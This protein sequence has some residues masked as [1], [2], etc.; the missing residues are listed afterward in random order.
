MKKLP[1]TLLLLVIFWSSLVV[2]DDTLRCG[3]KLVSVGMTMDEVSKACGKPSSSTTEEQDVRSGGRVVG[4]TQVHYWRY[5]R[6]T[7]QMAAVLQ[8][9]QEKLVS[10]SYVSK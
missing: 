7:G 2:A 10:I 1:G 8:F 6:A 5:N 4:K 3:N 9:D